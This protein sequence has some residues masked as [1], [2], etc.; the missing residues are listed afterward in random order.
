M[1][2]VVDGADSTAQVA[3]DG[4]GALTVVAGQEDLAA[5]HGEGVGG[6]QTQPGTVA[7]QQP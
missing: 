7:A 2:R 1:E 4:R 3:G 6:P 5:A